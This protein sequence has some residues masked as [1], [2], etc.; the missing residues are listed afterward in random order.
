MILD[1]P[2]FGATLSFRNAPSG[3]H[4]DAGFCPCKTLTIQKHTAGCPPWIARMIDYNR[5]RRTRKPDFRAAG[6]HS[7]YAPSPRCRRPRSI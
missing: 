5:E 1:S 2:R 6:W 7:R 4:S 3:S